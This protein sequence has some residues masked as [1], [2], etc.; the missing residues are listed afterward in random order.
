MGYVNKKDAV[1]N[2]SNP[3]DFDIFKARFLKKY[4][5][6]NEEINRL[7]ENND[8][9]ILFDYIQ[10]INS[11]AL[12]VGS[13]FLKNDTDFVLDKMKKGELTP[14]DLEALIETIQAVY[15]ELKL[16]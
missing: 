2:M 16:L 1:R 6:A 15:N 4:E 11:I 8:I 9:D 3:K 7:Y 5:K 12:N 14:S 13:Q 10:A